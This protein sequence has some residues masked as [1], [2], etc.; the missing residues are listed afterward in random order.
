MPATT[1]VN[2]EKGA[3]IVTALETLIAD[4]YALMAQ[5]HLAHWNVE[6][7]DFFQLH[8]AFQ[9]QYEEL[10]TAVDDIA[11]HL[12][13]LEAYAPGG[14]DMLAKM[15]KVGAME[16]RLPAKDY[17]A[18]LVEYHELLVANAKKGREI[19]GEAGDAETEDLFI[20]RIRVHEKTLWM[21]RSYL[22]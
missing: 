21:L 2:T 20:E 9:G 1:T 14:L 15:S 22:K 5:T 4:T 12:R 7:P 19:S 6:G 18:N 10:F 3:E 17:V 8:V 11:E 13:T 16:R